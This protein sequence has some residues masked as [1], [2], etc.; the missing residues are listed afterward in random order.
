MGLAFAA[1]T[2]AISITAP[3]A[4]AQFRGDTLSASV[5]GDGQ[6]DNGARGARLTAVSVDLRQNGEAV[7]RFTPSGNY[8]TNDMDFDYRGRWRRDGENAVRVSLTN[9]ASGNGVIYLTERDTIDRIDLSGRANGDSFSIRFASLRNGGRPGGSVDN[10]PRPGGYGGSN[11]DRIPPVLR[12]SSDSDR[13]RDDNYSRDS[14]YNRNGS[15]NRDDSNNR[16]GIYSRDDNNN[17]DNGNYNR[18]QDNNWNE[19]RDGDRLRSL[20]ADR[21]GGGKLTIEGGRDQDLD[22]FEVRLRPGG[23]AT[24]LLHGPGGFDRTFTGQWSG[25][26]LQ[27]VR[28]GRDRRNSIE[29][30]LSGGGLF[31]S[32]GENGRGRLTFRNDSDGFDRLELSGH[33]RDGRNDTDTFR[34][35]F[36]P[37]R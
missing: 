5:R 21:R 32:K 10:V 26:D 11:R 35:S 22:R 25:G 15:Y 27:T 2:A 30:T 33:L 36:R 29:I 7:L 9:G 3:S 18:N 8:R 6:L 4:H 12:P 24:I 14:N 1:A 19:R 37:D 23:G 13:D 17:R 31:R 16:D 20:D 28:G 34:V